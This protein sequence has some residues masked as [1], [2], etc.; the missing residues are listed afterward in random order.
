M[1]GNYHHQ[2]NLC[3]QW[4]VQ[5]IQTIPILLYIFATVPT[6]ISWLYIHSYFPRSSMHFVENSS[7][8]CSKLPVTEPRIHT[9][10]LRN[11]VSCSKINFILIFTF[12]YFWLP[13]LYLHVFHLQFCTVPCMVHAL[14]SSFSLTWYLLNTSNYEVLNAVSFIHLP[15]RTKYYL[16]HPTL[17][18]LQS[19]M[20][21]PNPSL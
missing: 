13:S 18:H 10:P 5:F 19:R 16:E 6:V 21:D 8:P 7:L 9:K 12:V 20:K 2:H 15:T 17:R 14:T 4:K 1:N 11:S 3:Q